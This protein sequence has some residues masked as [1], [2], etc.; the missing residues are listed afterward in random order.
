MSSW[1][2]A[3]ARPEA[4]EDEVQVWGASLTRTAAEY[5]ALRG[6][7]SKDELARADAFVFE[8]DRGHFVAARGTLRLILA[9]YLGVSPEGLRFAYNAFG[10]PRLRDEGVAPALSF[11]LSHAGEIALYAFTSG[12]EVGIDV[13]LAREDMDCLGVARHFFSP[14]ERAALEALP[15]EERTRAFFDCW[16]R[17]EAYIKARGG[18]LSIPLDSFDVSLTP[19]EPAALLHTRED[20]RD[21][22]RWTLREL[23]PADGYAA[24]V[25]A[26]G[27]GWRLRRWRFHVQD[28][29][30]SLP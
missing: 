13:E 29:G 6:L 3:P 9:C 5:E 8:R 26:E 16:T 7:L 15:P 12:R 17:K 2:A 22:A 19:G 1:D 27:A 30:Q 14:P 11:N 18:G 4:S 21:A 28:E 10:K 23:A 20:P 25:A 24:T